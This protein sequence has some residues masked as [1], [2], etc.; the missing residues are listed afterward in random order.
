MIR[1]PHWRD[2]RF[3]ELD[4]LIAVEEERSAKQQREELED[5]IKCID[6]QLGRQ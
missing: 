1:L 3:E 2:P 6:H 5:E 4:R